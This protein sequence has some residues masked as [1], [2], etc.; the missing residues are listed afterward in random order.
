MFP[1]DLAHTARVPAN[2]LRITNSSSQAVGDGVP[3][4]F[5]GVLKR[6][7]DGS[8]FAAVSEARAPLAGEDLHRVLELRRVHE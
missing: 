6:R 7:L 3:G 2:M 5:N 8:V 1:T 4:F